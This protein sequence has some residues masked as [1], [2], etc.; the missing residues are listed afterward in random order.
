[1]DQGAL[2]GAEQI[3]LQRRER[4]PAILYLTVN[5]RL[6]I[7]HQNSMISTPLGRPSRSMVMA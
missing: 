6:S 1:M 7:D 3:V 2:A 5:G 4:D